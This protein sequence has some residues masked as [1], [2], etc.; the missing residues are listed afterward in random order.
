LETGGVRCSR[1]LAQ[2][3]II[4]GSAG[5]GIGGVLPIREQRSLPSLLPVAFRTT[6]TAR[7]QLAKR[8][9]QKAGPGPAA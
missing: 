2:L 9:T 4:F 7:P 5:I 8:C 3:R 1:F 6:M